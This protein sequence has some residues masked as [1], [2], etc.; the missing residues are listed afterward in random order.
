MYV[1]TLFPVV[2]GE[3]YAGPELALVTVVSEL[4][5]VMNTMRTLD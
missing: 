2:V 3:E 1:I 5:P 4:Y